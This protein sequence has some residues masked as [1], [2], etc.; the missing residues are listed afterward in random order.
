MQ[1]L[2]E[3]TL[4]AKEQKQYHNSKKSPDLRNAVLP[5]AI[6]AGPQ[7]MTF[8]QAG[9]IDGSVQHAVTSSTRRLP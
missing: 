3:E 2:W 4:I 8:P 1:L 6:S 7:N 9:G 5:E